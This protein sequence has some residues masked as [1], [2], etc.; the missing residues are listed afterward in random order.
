M[1][2]P[3]AGAD[4]PT[5]PTSS[6]APPFLSPEDLPAGEYAIIELFGHT[7]LV[8]RVTEVERFGGKFLG[9]EALLNGAILPMALHGAGAVYRLTPCTP[10]T[11]WAHQPT[12]AYL[13]PPA[14]R[15]VAPP[16]ALPAPEPV[17]Q[18]ELELDPDAFLA[19]EMRTWKGADEAPADADRPST[20]D[21]A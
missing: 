17:D 5:I 19:E 2:H 20:G 11:A 7:T 14:L 13:L 4:R 9:I 12:R 10:V 8:G 1:S 16:M 21:F 18:E 15:A 3:A 6:L